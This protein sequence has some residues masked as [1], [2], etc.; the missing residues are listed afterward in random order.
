ML[1]LLRDRD[2]QWVDRYWSWLVAGGLFVLTILSRLPGLIS[3]RMYNVDESYLA[4]MGMTMGRGGEL[5]IDA[6]DR[7]PPLLPWLYSLSERL[8]G[9]VDLR[10][11]RW[12]LVIGVAAAGIVAARIV[13]RLGG[14]RRGAVAA[15]V[16][17]VLGTV[18]FLPADGQ[19]A[20]FELFALLPACASVWIALV[21][22]D[23]QLPRSI[24]DVGGRRRPGGRGRHGQATVLRHVG[25][26]RV[27][28]VAASTARSS[29]RWPR[30]PAWSSGVV[31]SGLP[32]GLG[33]V[34]EWA[35]VQTSDF[36][37]GQVGGWR[38]LGVLA[39]VAIVFAALHGPTLFTGWRQRSKLREVDAVVWWWIIGAVIAITPGFRFIFHYF[40][41]LVP[42][43]AVLA[44][45][46]LSTE[47]VGGS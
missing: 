9:T 38:V 43:T 32:F 10:M 20:N 45:C 36:L 6:L 25:P 4:A 33:R 19:A 12:M 30:P 23:R 31:V 18:A 5:Y 7:K 26:D 39:I 44:G 15:G 3:A 2:R 27:C 41:L 11:L 29:V 46:L 42:P 24:A 35:W 8:L 16:L 14:S 13:L 22:R 47:S 34:W 40:Q 21:G 37:D 17:L 28:R 1:D